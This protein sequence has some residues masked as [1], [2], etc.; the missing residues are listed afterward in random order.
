MTQR[1]TN[2]IVRLSLPLAR[3]IH[4]R[5]HTTRNKKEKRTELRVCVYVVLIPSVFYFDVFFIYSSS[6]T[7]S[8]SLCAIKFCSFC[9]VPIRHPVQTLAHCITGCVWSSCSRFPYFLHSR[10]L[11]ASF[12]FHRFPCVC[13]LASESRRILVKHIPA[14]D[15]AERETHQHTRLVYRLCARISCAQ[16]LNSNL[17]KRKIDAVSTLSIHSTKKHKSTENWP[18]TFRWPETWR[19]SGI[20]LRKMRN[21]WEN[22]VLKRPC[23]LQIR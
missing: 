9:C 6:S 18:K 4:L 21:F 13:H 14:N 16:F 19:M 15:V 12:S 23:M 5:V 1:E 11:C 2:T 3:C 17:T 8:P 7:A 22:Y 10:S 20:Y